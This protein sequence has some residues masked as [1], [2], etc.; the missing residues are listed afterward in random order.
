MTETT[1]TETVRETVVTSEPVVTVDTET[2]VLE[3]ADS[4]ADESAT[5]E[6]SDGDASL[7]VSAE[8]PVELVVAVVLGL[9]VVLT[10]GLRKLLSK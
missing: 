9:V 10:L 3:Q 1:Q 7:K 6:V 8:T 2:V 4:T 5:V